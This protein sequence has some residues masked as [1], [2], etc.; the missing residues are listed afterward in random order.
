MKSQHIQCISREFS[1]KDNQ[2]EYKPN[3]VKVGG[4]IF[5]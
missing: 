4:I 2:K 1:Q 5:A 3:I